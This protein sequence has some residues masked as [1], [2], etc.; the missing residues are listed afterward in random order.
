MSFNVSS[1]TYNLPPGVSADIKAANQSRE[2]I[3]S[4]ANLLLVAILKLNRTFVPVILRWVRGRRLNWIR[5]ASRD[6]YYDLIYR[7][8]KRFLCYGEC[9]IMTY[10]LDF[11]PRKYSRALI[12]EN[13][14]D[15]DSDDDDEDDHELE[16]QQQLPRAAPK[17]SSNVQPTQSS[18]P[19]P[20][21]HLHSHPHPHKQKTAHHTTQH[22]QTTQPTIAEATRKKSTGAKPPVPS[23][24]VSPAVRQ[25]LN[26]ANRPPAYLDSGSDDDE[27]DHHGAGPSTSPTIVDASDDENSDADNS[28]VRTSRHRRRGITTTS[29]TSTTSP[30]R[31]S[32]RAPSPHPQKSSTH[33]TESTRVLRRHESSIQT[34]MPV[35]YGSVP[36]TPPLPEDNF[37]PSVAIPFVERS[38]G[39]FGEPIGVRGMSVQ[40]RYFRLLVAQEEI[41]R[42]VRIIPIMY[43][44][45][46]YAWVTIMSLIVYST[47]IIYIVVRFFP[48]SGPDCVTFA[49]SLVTTATISEA[50]KLLKAIRKRSTLSEQHQT[51]QA[52]QAQKAQPVHQKHVAEQDGTKAT[53]KKRKK[54]GKSTTSDGVVVPVQGVT[55]TQLPI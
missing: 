35:T 26:S 54:S 28:L 44:S 17:I 37:V 40:E 2:G 46:L 21:S 13:Q 34:Q 12:Q 27:D 48:M 11:D 3:I 52:Q 6:V 33:P 55:N 30:G 19:L 41:H 53:G 31:K 5:R 25:P 39:K 8:R 36:L 1:T 16:K 14:F 10:D 51:Q 18:K 29:T 15:D 47:L 9:C 4:A 24:S 22:Q 50:D 42:T 43:V 32:A 38:L 7:P 45:V 23:H 20:H 49:F